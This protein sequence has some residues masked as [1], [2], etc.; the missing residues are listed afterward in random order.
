[1]YGKC[2]RPVSSCPSP[3]R[4]DVIADD[5]TSCTPLQIT[6]NADDDHENDFDD[7]TVTPTQN[8]KRELRN[9]HRRGSSSLSTLYKL[10]NPQQRPY[11]SGEISISREAKGRN[12][13]VQVMSQVLYTP[14][15]SSQ[16]AGELLMS[17]EVPDSSLTTSS[18]RAPTS[19]SRSVV[20]PRRPAR[21]NGHV[22]RECGTMNVNTALGSHAVSEEERR[23]LLNGRKDDRSER[24]YGSG[25]KRVQD[26]WREGQ[27]AQEDVSKGKEK[28]GKRMLWGKK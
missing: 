1:M 4:D 9:C 11:S 25:F 27:Q 13:K 22:E 17:S 2:V 10:S 3:Y 8:V 19:S 18:Q 15:L 14:V 5:Y 12:R 21:T 26:L 24:G 6:F 7:A 20:A 16:L 23:R 28:S